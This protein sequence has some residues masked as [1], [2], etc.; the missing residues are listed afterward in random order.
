VDVHHVPDLVVGQG[1]I[2]AQLV[3]HVG[4]GEAA[5][6][7][8]TPAE[9]C[10]SGRSGRSRKL[11]P[12]RVA[13]VEPA[14]RKRRPRTHSPASHEVDVPAIPSPSVTAEEGRAHVRARMRSQSGHSASESSS[15]SARHCGAVAGTISEFRRAIRHVRS[16]PSIEKPHELEAPLREKL[17]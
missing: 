1:S 6:P 11:I 8:D 16:Q 14:S 15:S 17:R 13:Q 10:R 3:A 4:C 12:S 9:R 7:V 2:L 5:N